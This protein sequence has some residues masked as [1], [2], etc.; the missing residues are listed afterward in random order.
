MRRIWSATL[1]AGV[2]LIGAACSGG[3]KDSNSSGGGGRSLFQPAGVVGPDSF[4]PTFELTQYDV[5]L[6]A[7]A[8]GT[9]DGSAPG[10]YAGRTYGGTGTN[11]CDVEAMI[12]F[13]TYYEDRGRAWA[14]VQGISFE[15]LPDYLRSLTPV[16]ALQNLNVQMFG[17]KNDRAYGYDAVIAAGTAIL[18]DGQGMPRARCAC[19]NPLLAPSEEPSSS[20]SI[21]TTDDPTGDNSNPDITTAEEPPSSDVPA[22]QSDGGV[23]PGD[24]GAPSD[25]PDGSDQLRQPACPELLVAGWTDYSAPNGDRWIYE[26]VL[27]QWINVSDV[28]SPPIES[29]VDLPGWREICDDGGQRQVDPVCPQLLIGGGW[30]PYL[31]INGD[32]WQFDPSNNWWKN[33]TVNPT[34]DPAT[35]MNLLPGWTELC[36]NDQPRQPGSDCPPNKANVGDQ[37]LAPDGRAWRLWLDNGS[38]LWDEL[39]NNEFVGVPDDELLVLYN[40]APPFE[41]GQPECP[42]K[43]AIVGQV[44]IDTLGNDWVFDNHTGGAYG[45]DN[46]TTVDTELVKAEALPNQPEGCQPDVFESPCPELQPRPGASFVNP[47]NGDVWVWLFDQGVWVND[48]D[49]TQPT[50]TNTMLLPGYREACMPPCPPVNIAPGEQ[51]HWIDPFTGTMWVWS[52]GQWVNTVDKSQTLASTSD[53]PGWMSLCA[54]PCLPGVTS[55]QNSFVLDDD[56]NPEQNPDATASTG[57]TA[58]TAVTVQPATGDI[59]IVPIDEDRVNGTSAPLDLCNSEGCI[60]PNA[61]PEIGHVYTDNRGVRWTYITAN[62]WHS[63]RGEVVTDA[64]LIPG[65]RENC[66]PEEDPTNDP[67]PP[68]VAK[69][70]YVDSRGT[71]WIWTGD[72]L[73]P[74]ESDHGRRWFTEVGGSPEFR[75][76]IELEAWFDDCPPPADPEIVP[77]A[78]SIDVDVRVQGP[79]CVG[80]TVQVVMFAVPSEGERI[81][82]YK[83]TVND[84][85]DGSNQENLTTFTESF[86]PDAVGEYKVLGIAADS[87]GKSGQDT[88]FVEAIDCADPVDQGQ[89]SD[90][91]TTTTAAPTQPSTAKTNNPPTITLS[92]K[93]LCVEAGSEG[94]T[95]VSVTVTVNDADGDKV[96]VIVKGSSANHTIPSQSTQVVGSGSGTYS[97]NVDY[98]DRGTTITI[99]GQADDGQAKSTVTVA[100]KVTSPGGCSQSTATATSTTASPKSTTTTTVKPGP[101]VT[102]KPIAT[103]TLPK[104]IAPAPTVA[105][106]KAAITSATCAPS[107]SGFTFTIK[108]SD[109]ENDTITVQFSRIVNQSGVPIANGNRSATPSGAN[110]WSVAL[111]AVDK[112]T[113][114]ARLQFVIQDSGTKTNTSGSFAL[115]TCG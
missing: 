95:K 19:G 5:D 71:S 28:T 33:V 32:E 93:T 21:S 37:W 57:V 78:S 62:V 39:D 96:A 12:R 113:A 13:L 67:C 9:V 111:S 26:R 3:D 64:A 76:T 87:S 83:I 100:I 11:I 18:I 2:L 106:Q 30:T 86:V 115:T 40:C 105:N 4:A 7:L 80:D 102:L 90:G 55:P 6:S 104:T 85:G 36:G 45:W 51:A 20:D 75:A 17:F 48:S 41:E 61:S 34:P 73:D 94:P 52:E 69:S 77:L 46:T 29:V 114:G 54:P 89:P 47:N 63:E 92:T 38:L 43:K 1:M 58:D 103:S 72:N 107:G 22:D 108:A 97:F 53:L 82:E 88:E 59:A 8:D 10:L 49:P 101:V 16:Y 98:K 68:E 27:G 79:V 110:T 56:G 60:E 81:T 99:D 50:I 91:G 24:S 42:P 66:L 44:W 112:Q 65:Y 23:Q 35:D 84:Q 15:E 109:A 25:Q 74:A 14:G 70:T 31:D